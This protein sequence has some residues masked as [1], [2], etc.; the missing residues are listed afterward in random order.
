[1]TLGANQ[2]PRTANGRDSPPTRGPRPRCAEFS[3]SLGRKPQRRCMS[4]SIAVLP[5]KVADPG[6]GKRCCCQWCAATPRRSA[7]DAQCGDPERE[8][9]R[10]PAKRETADLTRT[11]CCWYWIK[12]SIMSPIFE[13]ENS[14]TLLG[15]SST[16]PAACKRNSHSRSRLC[17]GP[18]GTPARMARALDVAAAMSAASATSSGWIGSGRIRQDRERQTD[19]PS[20]RLATRASGSSGAGARRVLGPLAQTQRNCDEALVAPS[21]PVALSKA[22]VG[23]D[24]VDHELAVLTVTKVRNRTSF[25]YPP[26]MSG[27]LRLLMLIP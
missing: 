26:C 18:S 10:I 19:R 8:T 25:R 11:V 20:E 3:H 2:R 5:S 16:S 24:V 7:A 14:W 12:S 13:C 22:A 27:P 4:R 6:V 21:Q 1:M 17:S 15:A 23:S 9:L